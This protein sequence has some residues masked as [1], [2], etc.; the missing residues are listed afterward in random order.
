MDALMQKAM[1]AREKA[2]CPY[3]GFAVG[4]AV[5]MKDGRI[6]T[7]CNVENAS[8][9]LCTCA[10]RTAVCKAVSEGYRRGDFAAVAI[11][12][13]AA[14]EVPTQPCPPCG[15]CRQILAQFGE[16]DL[17]IVLQDGHYT[18][19]ALLPVRFDVPED[20]PV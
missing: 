20:G 5:L 8:Y 9:P 3:S 19:G 6:F 14:G 10:E 15:A 4:A 2:F 16:D 13:G 17:R 1:E 7:G 12:G 18:L 11:C